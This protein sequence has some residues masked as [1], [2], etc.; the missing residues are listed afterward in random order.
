MFFVE[1][2][3]PPLK[4]VIP[5]F[6]SNPPLKTEFLSSHPFWKFGRRFKPP[7]P[8]SRKGGAHYEDASDRRD[9]LEQSFWGDDSFSFNYKIITLSWTV[10]RIGQMTLSKSWYLTSCSLCLN[11]LFPLNFYAKYCNGKCSGS[12]IKLKD[13]F[14]N[15]L[16]PFSREIQTSFLWRRIMQRGEEFKR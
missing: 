13:Y 5:L 3:K 11:F 10:V 16:I 4:K 8:L 14:I 9:I 2:L 6:H 15:S 7:P 1:K 12:L